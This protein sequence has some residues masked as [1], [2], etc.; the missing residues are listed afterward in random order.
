[1]RLAASAA[2]LVS[3]PSVA[4]ASIASGGDSKTA[5]KAAANGADAAANRSLTLS[6]TAHALAKPVLSPTLEDP[7]GIAPNA[8]K[9]AGA[10]AP[11]PGHDGAAGEGPQPGATPAPQPSPTATPPLAMTTAPAAAAPTASAPLALVPHVVSEQVAV[12]LRQAVR[13]GSDHIQIQLQPADLG[14]VEVKLNINHDG[15]V[16]MVVSADRSDTLNLLQQDASGLAQAL[17]DAGLQADNS[18]LSFNLRGG[19]QFQQQ[20]YADSGSAALDG[21]AGSAADDRGTVAARPALARHNGSLDI[22]V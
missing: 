1:M 6:D 16:T 11:A 4:L 22:Q 10:L 15:R 9:E 17:R 3:Q 14:A 21:D 7:A 5:T 12:T 18:S 8:L 13:E 2:N 19:Y 20:H